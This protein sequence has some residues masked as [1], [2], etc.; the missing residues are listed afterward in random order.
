MS[1]TTRGKRQETSTSV[2]PPAVRSPGRAA[3]CEI[4]A[5][6]TDRV[7]AA[8]ELGDNT[9]PFGAPPSAL[10]AVRAAPEDDL[11]RYPGTASVETR[12]LLAAYAGVRPEEIIT[13]CGSDDMLESSFAALAEPGEAVA[14]SE[15]TFSMVP[16]FIRLGGLVP[17][18]VAFKPDHDIDADALLATGARIIY[19]CTPNN[20]TG[21]EASRRAV[22]RVLE[23]APGIVVLDEAYAEFA[24]HRYM[25]LA[26]AHGRLVV[27]RTMS[28]AWGMAGMRFGY[29]AAAPALIAEIEKV[30]G[31]YRVTALAERAVVAALTQ[32]VDWVRHTVRRTTELRERLALDLRTRGFA[33]LPSA[34]NFLLVPIPDAP[35]VA[36]R[37]REQGVVVR[38]YR[39]VPGIGDAMRISVGTDPEIDTVL[40][41]F[42][43]ARAAGR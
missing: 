32:D 25:S 38:G 1:G 29:A 39:A 15:P 37:M 13:G 33:P 12:R 17:V 20:P 2:S 14:Y 36:A 26:P 18:P 23:H 6:N 19:L 10:R 30:R 42:D 11:F 41:A 34:A 21:T 43:A 7:A 4:V 22:E 3:L 31:P 27:T 8:C 16:P 24:E 40:R 9:N 5:Y 28:K 35:A